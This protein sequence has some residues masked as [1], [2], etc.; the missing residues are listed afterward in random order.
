MAASDWVDLGSQNIG[1]VATLDRASGI[2][3]FAKT[4]ETAKV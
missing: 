1:F 3:L 2:S 4:P